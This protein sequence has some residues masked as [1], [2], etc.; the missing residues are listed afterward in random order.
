MSFLPVHL[1]A[2]FTPFPTLSIRVPFMPKR[3]AIEFAPCEETES[4]MLKFGGD[5]YGM[6]EF[7]WPISASTAESMQFI[8]QIP[9]GPDLFPGVA[10]TV[11][12]LFMAAH[13]TAETWLPEGGENAVVLV[14]RGKT[15]PLHTT[16]S[17]P[18]LQRMVKKWWKR[19]LVAEPCV[20]SGE[21][22]PAE[23]PKFIPQELLEKLP[24]R[25]VTAYRDKL[26]GNKLGGTPG[27]LQGDGLPY[28]APWHLLLQL[29]STQV[30]FLINFGDAG[31]GYLF[32]NSIGTEGKF[33]WQ[34]A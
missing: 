6:P 22:T 8:C 33:L 10:E 11:A 26:G 9:F 7:L 2:D 32:L 17:A 3:A 19:S 15:T 4:I 16:G 23:D 28:P 18:P 25:Q 24:E 31:V 13:E 20:F 5:P 30:P 21:L 1:A 29:D 27:F 14:P 34:C 12:Y